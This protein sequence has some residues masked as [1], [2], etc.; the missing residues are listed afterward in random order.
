MISNLATVDADGVEK[1]PGVP[2]INECWSCQS[3]VPATASPKEAVEMCRG[4]GWLRKC[5]P[6][7]VCYVESRIR[8]GLTR[9]VEK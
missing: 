7:D 4:N 6:E 5:N 1:A 3:N 8:D 2:E 9:Q